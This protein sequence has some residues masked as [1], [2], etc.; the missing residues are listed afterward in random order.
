MV[1]FEPLVVVTAHCMMT[2]FILL[3]P[4]IWAFAKTRKQWHS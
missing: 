1:A 3:F 2:E 4:A